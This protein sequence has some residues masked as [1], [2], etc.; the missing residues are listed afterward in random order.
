MPVVSILFGVLLTALGAWG[1]LATGRTHYT[2]LIPVVPG[3]LLLGLGLLGLVERFLKHAMHAAAVVGLLGCVLAAG[4]FVPSALQGLD[5]SAK[6]AQVAT[7]G[8]TLLC[9][10]FVVFCVNSFIQAR[11]RRVAREQAAA[12]T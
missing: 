4:R 10:L 2:A 3:V 5:L 6:P 1:F 9:G 7:G 8:M 11:R 12:Q